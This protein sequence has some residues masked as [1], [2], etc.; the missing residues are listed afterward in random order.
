MGGPHTLALGAGRQEPPSRAAAGW[1]VVDLFSG[2]GGMSYGFH[3]HAGFRVVGAVDAQ[4][5]KPSTGPGTLGCN[6]TYQANIGVRPV[7]TDLAVADPLDTCQALELTGAGVDVLAA[8]PP[9]TGFSRALAHNHVRDDARNGLVGKISGYV[10]LLRPQIVLLENAREL[11]M[12]RFSGHLRSLLASLS[13]LGYDTRATTHFLTEFGL[14]QKRERA[15]VVAV[16]RPLPLRGLDDLWAGLRV[17]PK[18]THVRRA[19]WELA[20]V[21]AGQADAGDALHVSPAL[22]SQINRRRLAAIPHDGGGWADLA[23]HPDAAALLTPAMK[24]RAELRDFGSHPDVYGRLWWDRP[25]VTIKRECG[26]IGNGRYVHPEQD[27]LCTVR[28]MS[29]LQGFPRDYR[30]VGSLSN[31]YRHVGDAVP[32]LISYQL[33]VLCEWVLTGG[34]PGPGQLILRGCHLSRADLEAVA[35]GSGDQGRV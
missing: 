24:R 20:P 6:A 30:F 1:S 22:S 11:V 15:L 18:A 23:R 13:E 3:A 8:C 26:H 5:G 27:R 34:R 16:R 32:P 35:G 2:A 33:A 19:L 7:Q 25:A 12:G 10:E 28:E 14:P 29:I 31:M 17:S 9:C 21:E 4:L